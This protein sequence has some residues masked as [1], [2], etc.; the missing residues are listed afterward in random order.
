MVRLNLSDLEGSL[1][2]MLSAWLFVLMMPFF[3]LTGDGFSGFSGVMLSFFEP[4][5]WAEPFGIGIFWAANILYWVAWLNFYVG[6]FNCLPAIP[7]DG[8][9]LFRTYFLKIAEKFKMEETKAVRLSVRVS[10]YLTVFVFMS[11]VIMFVWPYLS[12]FV[13]GLFR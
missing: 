9:H 13:L 12:S 8:G 4:A 11:F 1:L 6:L 3:G 5:G 10:S 2:T 7:L